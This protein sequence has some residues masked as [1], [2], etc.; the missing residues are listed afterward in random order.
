MGSPSESEL[1]S[2]S[3]PSAGCDPGEPCSVPGRSARGDAGTNYGGLDDAFGEE[4]AAER[5][6]F[7]ARA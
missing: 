6:G 7:L 1:P 3:D 5:R 2:A 4:D